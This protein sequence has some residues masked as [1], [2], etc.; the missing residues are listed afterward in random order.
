MLAYKLFRV[1]KDGS[2]TSLFI[3]KKEK[4]PTGKWIEAEN[5]PTKGHKVRQGW[6]CL[7]KQE[8]PHL[9]MKNRK[10]FKV[11]IGGEYEI[12]DRPKSQG[13]KWILAKKIK[14]LAG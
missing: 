5:H 11:E 10:W 4:L 12:F 7:V 6:H 14:I 9:S 8:A 1:L 3:N 2:I 13:G